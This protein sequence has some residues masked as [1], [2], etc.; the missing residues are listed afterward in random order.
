M[1]KKFTEGCLNVMSKTVVVIGSQ[2]GDEGKGKIANFLSEQADFVVRYQGG[3]NAGHTI[4][5]D[6][7]TYKLHLIPSGVF[8]PNIKNILGNGM[9]I[10]PINLLQEISGLKKQGFPCNNLYISDR[11]NVIMNYHME[12]DALKEEAMGEGKIGTTKKGIGPAYTDKTAR[13]G[14]RIVDFISPNFPNLYKE[15]LKVKN[16]VIKNMGGKPIDYETSLATYS[17]VA[18]QI[19]PYVADTITLLNKGIKEGKKVVFEGAQGALLDVDFGSYPFVTSSNPTSGGACTGSGVGPT[20]IDEVIGVVKAYST[21]VGS[22]TFPTEFEDE[23]AKDIRER[24][25]EYGTTTRRPRRIGWLD[26]VV[27]KYSALINGLTGISLMLL[28]ILSGLDTIKLCCAYKLDGEYIDYIPADNQLLEHCQPVYLEMEGWQEDITK[29]KSFKELPIN[30]QRYIE[31]IEELT[32]VKVKIF[33]VGPDKMQ[34]I[35][36]ENIF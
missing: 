17:K 25:N 8:N 10:N 1:L 6:G 19:T 5:F 29:V 35:V 18:K 23:I 32:N 26:C 24:A 30:A 28:D 7:V 9:V 15:K 16:E 14:I 12:I 22:G 36:R 33:S 2:W 20:K 13:E 11:A 4:K 34:T 21:R 27:L 31:K 3:D